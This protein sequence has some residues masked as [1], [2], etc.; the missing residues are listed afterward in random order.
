MALADVLDTFQ[1][2]QS[3]EEAVSKLRTMLPQVKIDTLQKLRECPQSMIAAIFRKCGLGSEEIEHLSTTIKNCDTAESFAG[4]AGGTQAGGT[5]KELKTW[6]GQEANDV[7]ATNKPG[8]V[9]AKELE[10]IVLEP[11][12]VCSAPRVEPACV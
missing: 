1:L 2:L 5:K 10:A 3:D 7:H 9:C 6:G 12:S 11:V 4:F 8:D